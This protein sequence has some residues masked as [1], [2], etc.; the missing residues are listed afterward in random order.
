VVGHQRHLAIAVA[1]RQV[2]QEVDLCQGQNFAAAVAERARERWRNY[3]RAVKVAI[4]GLAAATDVVVVGRE[5][6][7]VWWK[8]M[9]RLRVEFG[10]G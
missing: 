4:A 7:L 6:S 2:S 8:V 9:P 10:Q 5:D 1:N 3:G